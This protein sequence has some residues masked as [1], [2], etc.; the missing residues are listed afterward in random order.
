MSSSSP[1]S[2]GSTASSRSNWSLSRSRYF[3]S[4]RLWL[5][6]DDGLPSPPVECLGAC[7]L[8]EARFPGGSEPGWAGGLALGPVPEVGGSCG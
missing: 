4:T 1:C 8:A 6:P 5:V 3:F 2:R 7:V